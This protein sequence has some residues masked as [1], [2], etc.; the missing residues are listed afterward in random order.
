M[1]FRAVLL[2][3][4]GLSISLAVAYRVNAGFFPL[5]ILNGGSGTNGWTVF[6]PTT[7]TGSCG[8]SSSNY[9]GTC[10]IYVDNTS[11]QGNDSTCAASPP[12]VTTPSAGQ[13][14]ATLL[15]AI[16][17]LRGGPGGVSNDWILL[18]AGDTFVG[19]SFSDICHGGISAAQPLLIGTYGTGARPL[20]EVPDGGNGGI[21]TAGCAGSGA[22]NYIAVV[23][24]EFYSYTRD[25][26]SPSYNPNAADTTGADFLDPL[27]YLLIENCKFSFFSL[28]IVVDGSLNGSNNPGPV[29]IRRNVIVDA[30]STVERSQGIFVNSTNNLV[31]QENVLDNNGWNATVSGAG[32]TVFNHNMYLTAQNG[33]VTVVG[34]VSSNDS[35]G[36]QFRSG[37]TFTDNTFIRDPYGH[38][39][40][41]PYSGAQTLVNNNV[42]IEQIDN[43][44]NGGSGLS[45]ATINTFSTYQGQDFNLGTATYSGNIIVHSNT[46]NSSPGAIDIDSGQVGS[47]LSNNIACDWKPNPSAP[48]GVLIWDEDTSTLT[49]NYQDVSDCDHNSYPSPDLTVGTYDTSLNT[50]SCNG[51]T[52]G[53]TANFICKARQQSQANWSNALMADAFNTYIR[54]GFGVSP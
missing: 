51:N 24:I 3:L 35:S 2:S 25:P 8:N 5:F 21:Q 14:C 15:R 46:P 20:V 27:N 34:N 53:T 28:N 37:G 52:V 44:V 23:G 36:A 18:N 42:H 33:P 19:Q 1:K 11:G 6:T 30:Y 39:I 50:G 41:Q 16:S 22:D 26:S 7:G 10:I 9:T 32:A 47:V 43:T 17:L 12:P 31:V 4:L 45:I 38:N 13:Q 29:T 54:A 40:G 48:G 49:G